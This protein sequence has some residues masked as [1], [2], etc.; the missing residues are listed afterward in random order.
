M[1]L[2]PLLLAVSLFAA[3]LTPSHAQTG[4]DEVAT[5]LLK[6]DYDTLEQ[7]FAAKQQSF[8]R[9]EL[10]EV[11][12][13][14]A[15]E[16]FA[17]LR[18]EQALEKLREWAAQSPRSYVAHLALGLSYRAQGSAARGTKSW[19]KTAPEKQEGLVRNFALA[20]PEL[21]KSIT[22]T[23]KPYLSLLNMMAIAGNVQNRPFLNATLLL[24][25]EALP[26]NLLARL[27]YARFLLPRWGGSHEKLDAFVAMSRQQGVAEGTLLKLQAVALSD[28]GQALLAQHDSAGADVLFRQALQLARQSGDDAG[29]FRAAYLEAAVKHVCKDAPEA[30]VCQP[31]VADA[32]AMAPAAKPRSSSPLGSDIEHAVY[33][34]TTDSSE[35]V[36]TE[37]AWLALRYPGA[38]RTAQALIPQ[39][40]GRNYDM[41]VVT[42]A[43]GQELKLYFEITAFYGNTL[44]PG[45]PISA[46][47]SWPGKS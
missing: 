7:S 37:Y 6:H 40:G 17:V 43:D 46:R 9:G 47:Q 30:P 36:R 3:P 44:N 13:R 23:A 41:L 28:S 8:E 10:T 21:R 29:G 33:V 42:T 14:Q 22:L 31:V 39:D 38:K 25:N 34:L 5:L 2:L 12:L 19:A 26:D 35:G 45:P 16:P 1:K 32:A 20:E 24:A 11:Q 18:D 4:Q 15:F 27:S